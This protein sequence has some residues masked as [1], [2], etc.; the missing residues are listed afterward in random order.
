M[1]VVVALK[2]YRR[3]INAPWFGD[4]WDLNLFVARDGVVGTWGDRVIAA[5]VDDAGRDVVVQCV[6]TGDA[7]GGEWRAPTNPAGCVWTRDQ[8]IPSGLIL[9]EHKGRP[10]LLQVRPFAYVRWKDP[11]HVPTVAELEAR[12]TFIAMCGTHVHNRVSDKTPQVPGLDDS[13][14]CSVNLYQHEHAALIRLVEQQRDRLGSATVSPT[15]CKLAAIG[16]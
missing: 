12:P 4:P 3:T 9:G 11:S 1:S 16:L 6:A 8:H 2:S 15:Y 14:G 7:S 13:E 10:A 5:T